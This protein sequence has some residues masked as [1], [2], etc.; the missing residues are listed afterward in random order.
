MINGNLNQFWDTGWRN[1]DATIYYKE[2]IYFLGGIF[3][4]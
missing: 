3:G 2:Y 4:K 1:A